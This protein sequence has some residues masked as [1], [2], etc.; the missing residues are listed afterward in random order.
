MEATE[1]VNTNVVVGA[2]VVVVWQMK[3]F[4]ITVPS[5]PH[6]A[7]MQFPSPSVVL[8]MVSPYL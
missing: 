8:Y 4:L 2:A 1:V 3:I 5:A 6:S 7:V